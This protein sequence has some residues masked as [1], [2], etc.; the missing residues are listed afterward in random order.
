MSFYRSNTW[1]NTEIDTQSKKKIKK[2]L[3]LLQFQKNM[4]PTSSRS[5]PSSAT[6]RSRRLRRWRG[7]TTFASRVML[8]QATKAGMRNAVPR[9]ECSPEC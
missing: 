4:G 1:K 9:R 2:R 7:S 6:P 8:D 3:V 5:T